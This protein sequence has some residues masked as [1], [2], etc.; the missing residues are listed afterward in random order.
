[1][2]EWVLLLNAL[3]EVLNG[4][5]AIAEWAFHTRTG[6]RREDAVGLLHRLRPRL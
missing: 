5:A 1:M 6:W 2:D 4:P 3:N